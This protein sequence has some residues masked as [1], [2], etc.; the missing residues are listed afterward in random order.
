MK[1]PGQHR[2]SDPSENMMTSMIDVVFLLLIFFVCAAAGRSSE[3]LLRTPLSGS[4]IES[5]LNTEN[6][7]AP[8]EV[9]IKLQHDDAAQLVCELNGTSY[10]QTE[11]L[12]A[13][14]RSLAKLSSDSPIILDIDPNVFAGDMVQVYDICKAAGFTSIL[15]NVRP[16][17]AAAT[18]GNS[19]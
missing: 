4:G 8:D 1:V 19:N 18:D 10:P 11:K 16:D 17:A 2:R 7:T 15:F 14:L 6:E 9:W 12:K 3:A 5:E 13:T